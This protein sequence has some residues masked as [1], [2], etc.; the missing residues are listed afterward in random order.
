MKLKILSYNIHKG[1]NWT[2]QK[3]YLNEVRELIESSEADIVFLQEVVGQSSNYK[4]KGLIDAQFE[5]FADSIWPY[6]SYAK[7]SIYESGHHGNLILS[8]FPILS[9]ENIRI[10]TNSREQRGLLS[11][12]ISLP[13]TQSKNLFVVCVHLDLL[14][15]GRQIQ[16][17]LIKDYIQSLSFP[18]E[19]PQILAGD[20]NDWNQ[21]AFHVLEN[22]LNMVEV[23][24]YQYGSHA[25]TFPS[26]LPLFKLD[27]IY[28]KNITII[29]S[30]VLKK[31]KNSNFSDHL[32]LFCEIYIL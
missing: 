31:N 28:T 14:N 26:F 10:S 20:F 12:K 13:K 25:K 7:N 16:Y 5:F 6:Y 17:R 11:C 18:Q 22:E 19:V 9:W 3:Y 15:R 29:N 4:E 8:K 30:M 2:Q 32:P 24:K 23:H 21:K 1:F 27:R